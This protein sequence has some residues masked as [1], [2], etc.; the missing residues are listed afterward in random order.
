MYTV[1]DDDTDD[2][3]NSNNNMLKIVY[4]LFQPTFLQWNKRQFL[5]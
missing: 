5:T 2:D 4:T 1:D 3:N